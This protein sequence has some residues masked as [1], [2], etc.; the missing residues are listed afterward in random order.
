V[1]S[2]LQRRRLEV[3]EMTAVLNDKGKVEELGGVELGA[4]YIDAKSQSQSRSRRSSP[5]KRSRPDFEL[6][7]AGN[8]DNIDDSSSDQ[9]DSAYGELSDGYR[10]ETREEEDSPPRG[11]KRL[12]REEVWQ[13]S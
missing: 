4:K 2:F 12:R 10:C 6:P 7:I 13:C 5:N 8:N 3:D 1:Q 11:R 9:V